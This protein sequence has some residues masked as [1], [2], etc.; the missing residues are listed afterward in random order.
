MPA[1]LLNEG[2]NGNPNTT[3]IEEQLQLLREIQVIKF[4]A[5][6]A[7]LQPFQNTTVSYQVK[8]PTALKV[9]VTF[10]INGR[11]LG[12]GLQ[13]SASFSLTSSTTFELHAATSLTGLNIASA[14]VTVNLSQCQTGSIPGLFITASLK[15]N[16]DQSFAG[17]TRG[18]GSVVTLGSGTISIQIPL[19]LG[20]DN[21]TMDLDV[22]LAAAQNG[23][24]VSVTDTSV[25]VSIHLNTNLNVDSW[26][27][28]AMQ[29]I[30]QPF[31]QHIVDA[32]IVPAIS[33]QLM[34]QINQLISS[35][36]GSGGPLHRD[37]ALTSFSLT[38][39]G[40]AFT[41]CPTTP[42]ILSAGGLENAPVTSLS[43]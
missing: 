13:N 11:A 40:A 32:E 37:F 30:V 17:R 43:S 36:E 18:T 10:S 29:G 21:G 33:Q 15:S 14:P 26:C 27:S 5:S 22:E 8:L 38:S 1:P 23:Q 34:S 39:D 25:T 9:P 28:N 41:V 2:N 4:T 19:T 42:S 6:P 20:G 7:N 24:T 16:I 31:M 35:A 12:T 3:V